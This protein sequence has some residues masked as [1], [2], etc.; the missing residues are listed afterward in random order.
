M[1]SN[2]RKSKYVGYNKWI[3][4]FTLTTKIKCDC[5]T[6]FYITYNYKEN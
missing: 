6:N 4:I 3:L 1:Y 5:G 2:R